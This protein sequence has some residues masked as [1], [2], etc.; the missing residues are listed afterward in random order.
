MNIHLEHQS[1]FETSHPIFESP[2]SPPSVYTRNHRP[3]RKEEKKNKRER[4]RRILSVDETHRKETSPRE[5][6]SVVERS[7]RSPKKRS[8]RDSLDRVETRKTRIKRKIKG[9]NDARIPRALDHATSVESSRPS[10]SSLI[11]ES[12]AEG[13]QRRTGCYF[14]VLAAL[15]PTRHRN[16]SP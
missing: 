3:N 10:I 7:A 1:I 13:M 5:I 11:A 9:E 4:K 16:R 15:W 6:V 14:N 8:N 12:P 2:R